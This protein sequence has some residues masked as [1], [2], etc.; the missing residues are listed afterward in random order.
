MFVDKLIVVA[1]ALLSFVVITAAL[2]SQQGGEEPLVVEDGDCI[3]VSYIA[4]YASNDTIFDTTYEF[5]ENR[6]GDIPFGAFV[7][8]NQNESSWSS[9]CSRVIDGLAE[10][11]IGMAEGQQK[12]IGPIPPS[13]AFLET[14]QVGDVF[15]SS[16]ATYGTFEMDFEVISLN[17]SLN[18][19]WS[20]PPSVGDFQAPPRFLYDVSSEPDYGFD[21]TDLIVFGTPYDL[22]GDG[23]EVV[24]VSDEQVTYRIKENVSV[25]FTNDILQFQWGLGEYEKAYLFV[26]ETEVVVKDSSFTLLIDPPSI[27]QL[28]LPV[29]DTLMSLVVENVTD[30]FIL[31]SIDPMEENESVEFVEYPRSVSFSREFVVP[32]YYSV[33]PTYF[34]ELYSDLAPEGL[35]LHFLAGESLIFDVMVQKIYKNPNEE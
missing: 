26:G 18:V 9:S 31:V 27:E 34:P 28:F 3:Y 6:S 20:N 33:D 19:F 5:L 13:K 8:L 29:G 2:V 35:S 1:I 11:L 4:R 15:S 30:E 14:P 21:V 32:R 25:G 12:T 7:S 17:D 23:V 16:I 10:G 24:N 22:F